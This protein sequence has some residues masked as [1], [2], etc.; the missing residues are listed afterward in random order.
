[1]AALL[2]IPSNSKFPLRMIRALGVGTLVVVSGC[3]SPEE[4]CETALQFS[5][6]IWEQVATTEQLRSETAQIEY[7]R[8]LRDTKARWQAERDEITARYRAATV[9]YV[10][11]CPRSMFYTSCDVT[12][13][14]STYEP[15]GRRDELQAATASAISSMVIYASA[16]ADSANAAAATRNASV[17]A[18]GGVATV[19]WASAQEAIPLA[20]A[21]PELTKARDASQ[22]AWT[23]CEG[24]GPSSVRIPTFERLAIDR[25][26][27]DVALEFNEGR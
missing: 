5:A 9:T 6:K 25:K 16:V 10:R 27:V 15:P 2:P 24:I 12:G 20:I 13:G 18:G 4:R 21:S 26:V 23:S 3:T 1:M 7:D 17:A 11:P 19:A 14:V 8:A 22:N